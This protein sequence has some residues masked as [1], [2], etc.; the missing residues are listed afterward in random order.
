MWSASDVH[1]SKIAEM[2]RMAWMILGDTRRSESSFQI[3]TMPFASARDGVH[4]GSQQQFP[5]ADILEYIHYTEVLARTGENRR[6]SRKVGAEEGRGCD[7]S[8]NDDQRRT[9]VKQMS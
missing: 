3:T 8:E 1:A 5:H 7:E 2:L 4:R 9:S 6:E